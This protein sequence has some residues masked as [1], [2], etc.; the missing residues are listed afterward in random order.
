MQRNTS[1]KSGNWLTQH[2]ADI[3]EFFQ[4]CFGVNDVE[5]RYERDKKEVKRQ[6]AAEKGRDHGYAPTE[7]KK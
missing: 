3:I 4:H 1:G 7:W 2:I 6:E 5:T